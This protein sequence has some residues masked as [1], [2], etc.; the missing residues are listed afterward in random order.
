[1]RK[2]DLDKRISSNWLL[3]N[4]ILPVKFHDDGA[5]EILAAHPEKTLPL[6]VLSAVIDRPLIVHPGN[7]GKIQQA[8]M[9]R[10]VER[11]ETVNGLTKSTTPSTETDSDDNTIFSTELLANDPDHPKIIRLVNTIL[12]NAVNNR[13]SDIHLEPDQSGL[14]IRL[15]IDGLLEDQEN[16]P[17]EY[18]ASVAN[19]IKVMAKMNVSNRL[20]PQDG[21]CNV[22]FGGRPIDIRVSAIPTP[23]GERIVLRL[24]DKTRQITKLSTLGLPS[25]HIDSIN[26][27]LKKNQGLL[28]VGGPTGSGKTTTLYGCLHSIDTSKRNTI[29]IEDPIEYNIDGISQIQVGRDKKLSFADGLRSLLRQDPDVIMVGE[30]RDEDTAGTALKAALTGHLILSTLHTIDPASA[31]IRLLDLGVDKPLIA[32]TLTAIMDQRLIKVLCPDCAEKSDNATE[33]HPVGC[34]KCRQTGWKGRTGLF[35]FITV[36]SELQRAIRE[37]NHQEIREIVDAACRSQLEKQALKLIASGK[38]TMAEV[39]RVIDFDEI[40]K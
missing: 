15:R 31:V 8:L 33:H 21:S 39:K 4:Q 13:A 22:T 32:E 24:L 29:T 6:D 23:S 27:I 26:N 20:E 36:S 37:G 16:V 19:R 3:S 35:R 5:L 9:Q 28:L 1:M 10:A 17:A 30:I 34:A 14:N 25:E 2:L 11:Q 18:S 12:A 38:T 7:P 40:R